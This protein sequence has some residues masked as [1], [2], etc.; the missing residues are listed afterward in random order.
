MSA[1]YGKRA[2]DPLMKKETAKQRNSETTQGKKTV[3]AVGGNKY[4][5]GRL[6]LWWVEQEHKKTGGLDA[7]A[8]GA[9]S[10]V[11]D[12]SGSGNVESPEVDPE[13]MDEILDGFVNGS[14]DGVRKNFAE[15]AEEHEKTIPGLRDELEELKKEGDPEKLMEFAEKVAFSQE[16]QD[17]SF[18]LVDA[19]RLRD[20]NREVFKDIRKNITDHVDKGKQLEVDPDDAYRFATIARDNHADYK[21]AYDLCDDY[22]NIISES[23]FL[24]GEAGVLDHL[25]EDL[26]V[27]RIGSAVKIG[28]YAPGSREWLE[29]RQ[30]GFGCSDYGLVFQDR[31]KKFDAEGNLITEEPLGQ[32]Y[33]DQLRQL[34]SSKVDEY[35]DE[36]VDAMVKAQ[37]EFTDAT[38]RGNAQEKFIAALAAKKL[39]VKVGVSK[40]TF[41]GGGHT[42]PNYDALILN[43]SGG[44]DGPLEIKTANNPDKFGKE[45]LGINGLPINYRSQLLAEM[46]QM[47]AEKGALAVLINEKELRVYQVSMD[48][49]VT[50]FSKGRKQYAPD[51]TAR[52]LAQQQSD[53]MDEIFDELSRRKQESNGKVEFDRGIYGK[54]VNHRQ[55]SDP[56]LLPSGIANKT[57]GKQ[58]EDFFRK[59]V[60]NLTGESPQSCMKRLSH[61]MPDDPNDREQMSEAIRTTIRESD[62]SSVNNIVV[63]DLEANSL[64]HS[65]GNI[66][67]DAETVINMRSGEITYSSGQLYGIPDAIKNNTGT[68]DEDIHHITT[69]MIDNKPEFGSTGD[70]DRMV[71]FIKENGGVMCA[72][73]KSYETG[74]YMANVPGFARAYSDGDIRVIDTM[75]YARYMMPETSNNRLS[76]FAYNNGVA[77]ENAHRAENDTRMTARALINFFNNGWR[78][79]TAN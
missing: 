44:I 70:P 79:T 1:N 59:M 18:T 40:G 62:L 43:G 64:S 5:Y 11:S 28:D 66:I 54:P 50:G 77:Y 48:D 7:S 37:T 29:A 73:N 13:L 72:H 23:V 41:N 2:K 16:Y 19:R 34:H 33:D 57:M 55:P 21:G 47:G 30:N 10:A 9:D 67:E 31:E 3:Y 20:E 6:N 22:K 61:N 24:A 74:Y 58:K 71:N 63:K 76:A 60:T 46:H 69:D 56:R 35:T 25:V 38:G 68:G 17:A 45:S 27:D 65:T 26:D 75:D 4:V 51:M 8:S 36:Q 39:G 78:S 14:T 42:N 49:V 15:L 32:Y 52:E 53:R 12:F